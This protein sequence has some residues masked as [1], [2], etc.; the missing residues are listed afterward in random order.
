MTPD[1]F[2]E[3]YRLGDAGLRAARRAALVGFMKQGEVCEYRMTT[4]VG[5]VRMAVP[6]PAAPPPAHWCAWSVSTHSNNHRRV[7]LNGREGNPTDCRERDFG[8]GPGV[9]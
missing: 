1:I 5:Y 3:R 7:G 9:S 2:W 4:H 8:F 6:N